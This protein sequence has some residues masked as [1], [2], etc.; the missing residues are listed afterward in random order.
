MSSAISARQIGDEA[1]QYLFWL[2]A[3]RML[4]RREIA[5]VGYETGHFRVFDD[6][7][8]RFSAPRPDGF[9]N[10]SMRSTFRQSSPPPAAKR[11]RQRRSPI[12][13]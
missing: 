3:G 1:Q 8:I 10:T 4:A 7:A 11:L 6:V 9:G 2:S 13:T 12:R 5:E